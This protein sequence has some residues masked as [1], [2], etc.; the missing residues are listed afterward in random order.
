[1]AVTNSGTEMWN[2]RLPDL[3]FRGMGHEDGGTLTLRDAG[4]QEVGHETVGTQ[5]LGNMWGH[6]T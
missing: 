6:G 4:T 3:G 2:L 5:G 1:M